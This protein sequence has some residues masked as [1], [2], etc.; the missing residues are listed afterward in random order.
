MHEHVG[1]SGL[2]HAAVV[3]AVARWSYIPAQA[4]RI[5]TDEYQVLH[6][7]PWWDEPL[8]LRWLRPR[9]RLDEVL[10]EVVDRC[11]DVG[12]PHVACWVGMGAPDGYESA[13]QR[14]GARLGET[15]DVLA[16]VLE[17]PVDVDVPAGVE[18][19]W[20]TD[21]A[22]FADAMRL[23]TEVF[24]GER[25]DDDVVA[26]EHAAGAGRIERGDGGQVVAYVDGVAAGSGGLSVVDTDA[27]LWGGAVL[28]EL[29]RRGVYRALLHERLRY[30]AGHRAT[31]ALVKARVE[32]SGPILRRAGFAAVGQERSW[33]LDL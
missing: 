16:R 20:A 32:S 6:L 1:H 31:L 12:P 14:R 26:S 2:D 30:A 17:R 21:L 25:P 24:G 5:E 3:E 11:S 29:R 13:L 23:A 18:L 15:L 33:L 7:P 9:R 4:T 10:D 22:T 28:P 27:R 8:E 19:R